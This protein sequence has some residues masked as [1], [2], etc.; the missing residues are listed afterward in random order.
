MLSHIQTPRTWWLD[1]K[2]TVKRGNGKRS[3]KIAKAWH[4]FGVR[5]RIKKTLINRHGPCRFIDTVRGR[6]LSFS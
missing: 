2:C 1:V 5:T 4:C 6:G 3:P